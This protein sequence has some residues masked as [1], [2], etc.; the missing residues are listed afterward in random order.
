MTETFAIQVENPGIK[1]IAMW[2]SGDLAETKTIVDNDIKKPS[3]TAI[4][5][6]LPMGTQL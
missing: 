6:L 3:F 2:H 5:K 4:C 1:F